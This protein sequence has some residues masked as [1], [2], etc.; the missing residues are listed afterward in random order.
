MELLIACLLIYG[1]KLSWWW[2]VVA[3]CIYVSR[4]LM[5]LKLHSESFVM[6]DWIQK[7]LNTI[8]D[9]INKNE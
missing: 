2:Y 4:K 1:F 6:F 3:T 7:A 9:N 5:R 8:N